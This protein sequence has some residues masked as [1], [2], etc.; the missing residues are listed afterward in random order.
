[1]CRAPWPLSLPL[2]WHFA[3]ATQ[4]SATRGLIV[5]QCLSVELEWDLLHFWEAIFMY[6]QPLYVHVMFDLVLHATNM[7]DYEQYKCNI[8]F[9]NTYFI[10]HANAYMPHAVGNNIKKLSTH[11]SCILLHL[12]Y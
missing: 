11:C 6:K 3:S 5:V 1:M 7:Q 10:I 9:C 8:L 2:G 4:E 12:A